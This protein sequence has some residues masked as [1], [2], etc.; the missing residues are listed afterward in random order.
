VPRSLPTIFSVL[1]LACAFLLLFHAAM[2]KGLN[3]DEHMYVA[4]GALVAREG[5]APYTGFTYFQMPYLPYLYALVFWSSESL[6]LTARLVSF[7]CSVGIVLLIYR[8]G[9]VAAARRPESVRL[10]VASSGAL[11]LIANPA[12]IHASGIAWNHDAAILACL[13]AF[14]L[15]VGEARNGPLFAGGVLMGVAIG[16]RLT[17][18]FALIPFFLYLTFGARSVNGRR[19]ALFALGTAIALVPALL[20][21]TTAPNRFLFSNV[22]YHAL[23]EK[24]YAATGYARAMD[25]PGKLLYAIEVAVSPGSLPLLILLILASIVITANRDHLTGRDARATLALAVGGVLLLGS[26][27][28]SPTWLQYFYAPVPFIIVAVV[29]SLNG[30]GRHKSGATMGVALVSGGAAALVLCVVGYAREG[31]LLQ[32]GKWVPVEIHAEGGALREAFSGGE[33]MGLA[34]LIPLEGGLEIYNQVAAGPFG[35]R[36]APLLPAEER[37]SYGLLSYEEVESGQIAAPAAILAGYEGA[38]EN[39]LIAFAE[40]ER[41]LLMPVGD[42]NLLYTRP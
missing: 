2:N 3:H 4:A 5:L 17:F 39:P 12:F 32:P 18:A 33:V 11:L 42:G 7:A 26:F 25:L 36:V 21:F 31:N 28:S 30:D 37:S 15:L 16:L 1:F 41:Y 6:L 19:S 13:L 20:L 40:R 24:Y 23:N 34:P 38:L 29:H 22:G 27:A 10:L 35:W 8:A 9:L 14:S